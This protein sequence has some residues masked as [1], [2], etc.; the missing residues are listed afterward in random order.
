MLNAI[1]NYSSTIAWYLVGGFSSGIVYDSDGFV[2]AEA[3]TSGYYEPTPMLWMTLHWSAFVTAKDNARYASAGTLKGGGGYV[4]LMAEGR[5]SSSSGSDGNSNR[6]SH[7]SANEITVVVEALQWNS[8]QCIRSNPAPYTVAKTQTVVISLDAAL[9]ASKMSVWRSCIGWRYGGGGGGETYFQRQQDANVVA[10]ALTLTVDANCYYTISTKMNVVRPHF[11][12]GT[13][14]ASHL[15]FAL[16]Y[17][18][19]FSGPGLSNGG[20]PVYFSDMLGK[21]ELV[22]NDSPLHSGGEGWLEQ[23]VVDYIPISNNCPAHYFP[24]SLI[25]TMDM[26]DVTISVDVAL[27]KPNPTPGAAPVGAFVAARTRMWHSAQ[28][29]GIFRKNSPGLF[30]WLHPKTWSLCTDTNC[31]AV[32]ATG[33]AP[34]GPAEGPLR[35]RTPTSAAPLVPAALAPQY[36]S[37]TLEVTGV[38]ASGWI[39]HTPIFTSVRVP[40][41]AASPLPTPSALPFPT[42]RVSDTGWPALGS[43][44]ASV[45]FRNF[46]LGGNHANGTHANPV[47]EANAAMPSAGA[48]VGA[49]PLTRITT[50]WKVAR[51][52]G[53]ISLNAAAAAAASGSLYLCTSNRPDVF[54]R[55]A[56][57]VELCSTL[58]RALVHDA[59]TGNI[60]PYTRSIRTPDANARVCLDVRPA[61]TAATTNTTVPAAA[62]MAACLDAA[63]VRP[64]ESQQFQYDPR[65]NVLRYKKGSCLTRGYSFSAVDDDDNYR[66][67]ALGFC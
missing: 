56:N 58:D 59:A 7:A 55:S 57:V 40:G 1:N 2:R 9:N 43:T 11:E 30:L 6:G 4:V 47:C 8:S 37:L 20:A 19:P 41:P 12:S 44:F 42:G 51:D 65:L 54:D 49:F 38:F 31:T 25:G 33:E 62:V 18:A 28:A 67:C 66:Q 16:P 3:P 13:K 46:T 53:I 5:K 50:S 22:N 23:K 15:G 34:E 10:G 27:P 35:A 48:A 24:S 17:H 39:N 60:V 21:F 52:T 45:R 64:S 29:D 36:R 63:L 26:A 32:L 14:T 61:Y